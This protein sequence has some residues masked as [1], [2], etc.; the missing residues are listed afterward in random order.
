M[1]QLTLA[2]AITLSDRQFEQLCQQNPDRNVELSSQGVLLMS[3][4]VGFE[5]GNREFNLA[6]QFGRWVEQDGTGVAFSSQTLFELPNGA[7]YMP[8]LAWVKRDRLATLTPEQKRGFAPIA[9]DF[10]IE[11]RSP[12]DALAPLQTKM[13]DYIDAGVCLA[14]LIDPQRR[15]VEVYA[16]G[17]DRQI[18]ENPSIMSGDPLL[19]G[20]R[21]NLTPLFTPI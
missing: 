9:P 13:L 1:S 20:F 18:L 10:V 12:S 6:L 14:W 7:K 16:A 17:C 3:P 15:V 4:P 2:P 8:D 21:L 19:P 11:L 5:G